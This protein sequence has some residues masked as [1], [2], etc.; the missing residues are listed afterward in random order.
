MSVIQDEL[1]RLGVACEGIS[2]LREKDGIAVGA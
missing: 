2:I 1:N